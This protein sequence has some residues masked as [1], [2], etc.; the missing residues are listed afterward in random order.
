MG[1]I[2][3][4]S[5]QQGGYTNPDIPDSVIRA[6]AEKGLNPDGSRMS[7]RQRL[8][9]IDA[10]ISEDW[11]A[12]GFRPGQ[13]VADPRAQYVG[14]NTD[15]ATGANSPMAYTGPE[16]GFG[17]ETRQRLDR[18]GQGIDSDI[19]RQ[20]AL[21]KALLAPPEARQSPA[22]PGATMVAA[23]P[24]MAATGFPAATARPPKP[25]PRPRPETYTV[26][27]GDTP[28]EIA[29]AMGLSL[30]ELERKNPGII[31]RA[32]RL[33]VGSKVRV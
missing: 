5:W 13:S 3:G 31:K 7:T 6:L 4:V 24:E 12:M 20:D 29:R 18:L 1:K 9:G 19:A 32:R 11:Q 17:A 28:S 23:R 8:D 27:A 26:K 30:R 15:I 21:V 14:S 25:T 22:A 16:P 2:S 10:R 33:K